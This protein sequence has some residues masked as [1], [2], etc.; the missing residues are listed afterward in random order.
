MTI[1]FIFYKLMSEV[2][3][4]NGTY[5]DPIRL[6]FI[7]EKAEL[8]LLLG[9]T[10]LIE[11]G[12]SQAISMN[13]LCLMKRPHPNSMLTSAGGAPLSECSF[14]PRAL[15]QV[16]VFLPSLLMGS[17]SFLESNISSI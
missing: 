4:H 8:W 16:S 9:I 7:L 6:H 13:S 10:E 5:P 14:L 2:K 11:R 3:G 17:S 12:K 1:Y 15:F